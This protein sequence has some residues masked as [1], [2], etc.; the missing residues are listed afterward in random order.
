M[1]EFITVATFNFAHEIIVL[2]S[3]LENEV[4]KIDNEEPLYVSTPDSNDLKVG[5][6]MDELLDLF[7]YEDEEQEEQD[8]VEAHE[9][10]DAADLKQ[11]QPG[12][13]GLG[14]TLLGGAEEHDRDQQGGEQDHEERDA[15]DPSQP[16]DPQ[17]R[18]PGVLCHELIAARMS[19]EGDEHRHGDAEREQRGDQA[20]PADRLA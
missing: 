9:A 1:T 3:I 8:Q 10:S 15:I 4:P 7:G 16:G 14:A 5:E 17:R 13:E 6:N 2:K 20:D 12:H 18:R 19:V 11:E